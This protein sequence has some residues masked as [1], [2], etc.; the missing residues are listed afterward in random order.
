MFLVLLGLFIAPGLAV[1]S[2]LHERYEL[3]RIYV[4]PVAAVIGC[5]LGYGMFWVYVV[6][7]RLGRVAT[8]A[9]LVVEVAAVI[10]VFVRPHWRALLRRLDVSGPLALLAA[11]GLFYLGLYYGCVDAGTS[12]CLTWT[13]PVDNNIPLLF[14]LNLR[15]GLPL[16]T[17]GDWHYSDRPPLQTGVVLGHGWFVL[18]PVDTFLRYELLGTVLQCLWV[19]AMWML[20]RRLGLTFRLLAPALAFAVFLGFFALNSVFVWPKLLAGACGAVGLLLWFA[21]RPSKLYWGLGGAAVGCGL[22]AHTGVIFTLVPLAVLLLYRRYRPQWK[23]LATAAGAGAALLVPWTVYQKLYD[24]PG[25]RL[26]K[27]HLGGVEAVDDRGFAQTVV[28]SYSSTPLSTLVI[29]RLWNLRMMV[30]W[31]GF[32]S[33]WQE[34]TVVFWAMGVLVFAFALLA[35]PAIRRRLRARALDLPLLKL[36][37]WGGLAALLFWALIMFGPATTMIHQG[38]YL[39]MMVLIAGLSAIIVTTLPRPVVYGLLAVHV[40]YFFWIWVYGVLAAN[41]RDPLALGWMAVGLV[42]VVGLLVLIGRQPEPG[43]DRAEPSEVDS[44]TPDRLEPGYSGTSR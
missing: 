28:D 11:A 27:W 44:P 12:N 40:A 16:L 21:E 32:P 26:L 42:A 4:V 39:T 31:N 23:V 38:S 6:S 3:G 20:G 30:D 37:L 8:D 10:A 35:F 22:L 7:P 9:L 24:P 13:L 19:P 41:Q 2:W 17:L 36:L 34:F 29:N 15:D 33:R 14:A 5:L 25:D 43:P 1:A 18:N